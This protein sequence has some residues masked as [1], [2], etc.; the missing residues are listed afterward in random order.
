MARRLALLLLVSALLPLTPAGAVTK[1]V[2]I[3]DNFF[4]PDAA[5]I[6]VGDSVHWT[7]G[8]GSINS[9]N[10]HEEGG[11]FHSGPTTTGPIDYEAVFSAGTF[12]YF[13]QFH[14]SAMDGFVRVPV[15]IKR[16][17]DGRP[18]T[19]R[20]AAQA[21]ETGSVYDVQFRVGSGDWRKWKRDTAALNGVFGKNRWPVRVR[22]GVRYSFRARS[23]DGTVVSRWSP[24]RSFRP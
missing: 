24:V 19:V 15:R 1:E 7:R 21:S 3:G 9:H 8:V 2:T 10:V 23:Q 18:F 5:G 22:N 11:L 6:T 16:A 20:W 13:C 14:G 12:Y 4:T 17:P